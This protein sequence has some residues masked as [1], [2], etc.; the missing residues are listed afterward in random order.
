MNRF[1]DRTSSFVWENVY[2]DDSP[3]KGFLMG[4][5]FILNEMEFLDDEVRMN[6][7]RDIAFELSDLYD[8][9]EETP[10]W[11]ASYFTD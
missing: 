8:Q 2:A 3:V 1:I 10:F 7:V 9:E 4:V 5:E 6:I 11:D